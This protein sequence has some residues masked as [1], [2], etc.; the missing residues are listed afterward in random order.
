VVSS[1]GLTA[2][3]FHFTPTGQTMAAF[4]T[5][6]SSPN[7]PLSTRLT[8]VAFT[9]LT[10]PTVETS[11]RWM[12]KAFTKQKQSGQDVDPNVWLLPE[13]TTDFADCDDL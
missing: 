11:T 6:F 12:M 9:R 2:T 10:G 1:T 7:G 13:V 3:G 4:S 8:V 5:E